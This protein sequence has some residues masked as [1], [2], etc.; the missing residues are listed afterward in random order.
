MTITTRKPTGRPS[1]PLLLAAGGEGAGKS[2]L[3]AQASAS[4]LIGRTLWIGHGEA[5]PDEYALIPGADFDI[6]EYDGTITGLRRIIREAAAEP[7]GDKPTLLVVDSGT[8][9]WDTISENAQLDAN[10]R[11]AR[12]GRGGGGDAT[13][14]VDIWNRH[15]QHWR[16]IVDTLRL[17]DGPAII[18]AR[19]EEVAAMGKD[20]R[21]GKTVPTGEKVWKVKAEKGLPYDVDA[22]V[23]MP[24]RGT[25][26]LSKVRSVRLQLDEPK[27]WPG[28]TMDAFWRALGLADVETG[29]SA[30]ATPVAEETPEADESGRDW[31]TEL[32]AAGTD[33]GLLSKLG[34]EAK[35]AHASPETLEQIR[36]A[37]RG[38]GEGATS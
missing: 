29:R 8:K 4:D 5:D 37:Y 2:F 15:K 33:R 25:Y 7:K 3:A 21:S 35:A 26:T 13:I 9:V 22:V 17:H 30:Y 10:Q 16:D 38:A 11:A 24:V 23:H 20:P 19:Y 18:T 12:N 34:V 31:L 6:V 32:T 14:G 1:W 27:D 28:F 36:V